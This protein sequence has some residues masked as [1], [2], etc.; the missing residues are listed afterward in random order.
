[1]CLHAHNI[2]IFQ[3][4]FTSD[5]MA[6]VKI[7]QGPVNRILGLQIHVRIFLQHG[8]ANEASTGMKS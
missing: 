3:H 1:M 5:L 6:A 7:L 8:R 2:N 4:V